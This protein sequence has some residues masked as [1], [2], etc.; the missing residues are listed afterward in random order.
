M[1]L[2]RFAEAITIAIVTAIVAMII[3]SDRFVLRAVIIIAIFAADFF[4]DATKTRKGR[5]S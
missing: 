5:E 3:R 4:L 2:R 1:T